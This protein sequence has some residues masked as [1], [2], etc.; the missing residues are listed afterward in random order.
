MILLYSEAGSSGEIALP[1]GIIEGRSAEARR[2]SIVEHF[3]AVE[4]GDELITSRDAEELIAHHSFR[5]ASADEQDAYAAKQKKA[6]RVQ[7]RAASA[8]APSDEA[9]GG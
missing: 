1:A 6:K 7:E 2:Y 5:L 4:A 3:C 9:N 8:S